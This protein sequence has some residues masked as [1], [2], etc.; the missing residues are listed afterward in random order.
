M[1]SFL[2]R[3]W[4]AVFRDVMQTSLLQQIDV[5]DQIFRKLSKSKALE[6]TDVLKCIDAVEHLILK[7]PP[8]HAKLE[9]VVHGQAKILKLHVVALLLVIPRSQKRVVEQSKRLEDPHVP[10]LLQDLDVASIQSGA[11]G[12]ISAAGGLQIIQMLPQA[13]EHQISSLGERDPHALGH[14][15]HLGSS[16]QIQ[17]LTRDLQSLSDS[18]ADACKVLSQS[19]AGA[20]D[21]ERVFYR[22]GTLLNTILTNTM[23]RAVYIAPHEIFLL[24]TSSP[25]VVAYFSHC[26]NQLTKTVEL[27]QEWGGQAN[28]V[29]I[30]MR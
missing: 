14:R 23:S 26:R 11:D 27:M 12:Q 20:K 22:L 13:V 10:P 24:A 29:E 16:Q 21:F 1:V 5:L 3:H 19:D 25:D 28:S 4:N 2:R 18:I 6:G 15:Q 30:G 17:A 7:V 8:E 9:L